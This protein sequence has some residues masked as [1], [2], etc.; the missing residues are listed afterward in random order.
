M[1]P[2]ESRNLQA[3]HR[4]PI[5][6]DHIYFLF[7]FSCTWKFW[8]VY[9]EKML[10]KLVRTSDLIVLP[11]WN[12]YQLCTNYS[13]LQSDLVEN[14][15]EINLGSVSKKSPYHFGPPYVYSNLNR[16]DFLLVYAE[17]WAKGLIFLSFE[18]F[19]ISIAGFVRIFVGQR[20][21]TMN[22]LIV[23]R[24]NKGLKT[25]PTCNLSH[26]YNVNAF[27]YGHVKWKK[28]GPQL[29]LQVCPK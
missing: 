19:I 10:T 9:N 2:K 29:I 25:E 14:L 27:P 12:F 11:F 13:G 18:F 5:L 4:I 22:I 23:R 16:G 1:H 15:R 8:R 28:T 20:S 26:I 6:L 7:L 3:L 21:S 17:Q 24:R